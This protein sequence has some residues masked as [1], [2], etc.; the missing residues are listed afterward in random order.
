[1]RLREQASKSLGR[2]PVYKAMRVTGNIVIDGKTS[3]MEWAPGDATGSAP[4]IH[5]TAELKWTPA[6]KD[7]KHSSHA[8]LQTDDKHL[9]VQFYN[10]VDPDK[11]VTGGHQWDRDD[12]VEIAIAEVGGKVG[13]V[14]ILRGYPDG[15]W[16]D[17]AQTGTPQSMV[18]RLRNGGVQYAANVVGN[19]LWTAEWKIPF[20]ALGL[21]PQTRNPRLAFNLSVRKPA[22]DQLVM[23]KQTGGDSWD[24]TGGTLLWLAQF[25]EVAIPNLKP[26]NAVLHVLSLKK[27]EKMLKPTGGCEVCEWAKPKGHRLSAN[28]R[29]LPTDSWQELSFSFVSKV[30]GDVSLILLGDGYTDPLTKTQLPVWVYMDDLR[31][32]G[33]E[34]VNG[35]FEERQTNG[36]PAAWRPHVKPAISIQDPDLAASGSWLVKVAHDRRF[37]QTLRLTSGQAVTVRAKVRGLPVQR[38]E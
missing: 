15:F 30:D 28:L 16:Q 12:A 13:P 10:D 3:V 11:G 25:G 23:L 5:E 6:K 17:T 33:A 24:V 9:Y 7:A 32:E 34:L 2:L 27:T 37:T 31:V 21:E 35:D 38:A 8:M 18:E 36:K 20:D 1:M 22:D 29:G 4:E 14:L 19:G 26:S